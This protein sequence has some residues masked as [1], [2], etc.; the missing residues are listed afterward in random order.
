MLQL[1]AAQCDVS[2]QLRKSTFGVGVFRS[3]MDSVVKTPGILWLCTHGQGMLNLLELRLQVGFLP[4]E[5]CHAPRKIGVILDEISKLRL[6]A[7][8]G[9]K[10]LRAIQV[11]GHTKINQLSVRVFK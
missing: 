8:L 6:I 9:A 7:F 4:S 5:F 11:N 1:F 2:N 10:T 3:S